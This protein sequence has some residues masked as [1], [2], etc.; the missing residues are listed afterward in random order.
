MKIQHFILT[1]VSFIFLAT[2]G[3]VSVVAFAQSNDGID[4]KATE[5]STKP[6]PLRLPANKDLPS[7]AFRSKEFFVKDLL[8][9]A[10]LATFEMLTYRNYLTKYAAGISGVTD[11]SPDRIVA[12]TV[13]NFP[14][15]LKGERADYSTARVTTA[16]DA[17]TGE[18]VSYEITGKAVRSVDPYIYNK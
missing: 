7:S 4:P 11:V 10:A 6:L 9:G 18:V 14:N 1:A 12:V 5:S 17:L 8:P 16:F 15:G 2:V 13:V 3:G